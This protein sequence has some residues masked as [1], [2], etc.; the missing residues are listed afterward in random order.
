MYYFC[1]EKPALENYPF[2]SDNN[3]P[4]KDISSILLAYTSCTLVLLKRL[5]N[6]HNSILGPGVPLVLE[7]LPRR[8]KLPGRIP[9][10]PAEG[11]RS[12]RGC[13]PPGPHSPFLRSVRGGRQGPA[14][15]DSPR[16]SCA[17]ASLCGLGASRAG[18]PGSSSASAGPTGSMLG[19]PRRSAETTR[20]GQHPHTLHTA[21]HTALP[22][23]LACGQLSFRTVHTSP[24]DFPQILRVGKNI[25]R[26]W[27]QRQFNREAGQFV[28]S[29]C[30]KHHPVLT[31]TVDVQQ[32]PCPTLCP[33]PHIS[34][35]SF[36]FSS[37][38]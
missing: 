28:R 7:E 5:K 12:P 23:R 36:F 19:W 11:E 4:L 21:S 32:F 18:G 35:T 22:A 9:Q 37:L 2:L 34:T 31:L 14:C 27:L 20:P 38:Y 10:S 8:V 16:S 25:L 15:S 6:L 13:A 17:T 29:H 24:T 33:H 26:Q 30:Q 1:R 3:I